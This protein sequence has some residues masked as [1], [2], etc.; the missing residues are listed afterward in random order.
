MD[1]PPL[2]NFTGGELREG[3]LDGGTDGVW[4][5][6]GVSGG[7]VFSRDEVACLKCGFFGGLSGGFSCP[8]AA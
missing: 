2:D 6:G 5:L 7:G 4:P 8:S 1:R 3:G